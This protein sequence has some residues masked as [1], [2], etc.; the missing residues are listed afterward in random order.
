MS[1]VV[2]FCPWWGIQCDIFIIT[3]VLQQPICHVPQPTCLISFCQR[4]FFMNV[5]MLHGKYNINLKKVYSVLKYIEWKIYIF[6]FYYEYLFKAKY[7][8]LIN[9]TS[10]YE[11]KTISIPT[12]RMSLGFFYCCAFVLGHHYIIYNKL[13]PLVE[14]ILVIKNINP[15]F[16]EFYIESFQNHIAIIYHVWLLLIISICSANISM[17][18]TILLPSLSLNTAA[19]VDFLKN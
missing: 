2:C 17:H 14:N 18:N 19:K 1:E 3:S 7:C 9:Q 16:K 4:Q 6:A 11:K 12:Y 5:C 13:D 8:F 15:V 10:F